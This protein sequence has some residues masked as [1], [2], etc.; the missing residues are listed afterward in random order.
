MVAHE[1]VGKSQTF[2]TEETSTESED[3]GWEMES[4][5]NC[6]AQPFKMMNPEEPAEEAEV[7]SE[8]ADPLAQPGAATHSMRKSSVVFTIDDIP[9]SKWADRFQE[10][11]AT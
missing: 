8:T 1:N 9:Y 5:T 6:S 4:S 3:S 2:R 11:L 10:F 7:L